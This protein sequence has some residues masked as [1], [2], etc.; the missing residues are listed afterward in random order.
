MKN[1]RIGIAIPEVAGVFAHYVPFNEPKKT[2]K[3]IEEALK[4]KNGKQF[5]EHILN[6]FALSK[7]DDQLKK[8]I[9]DIE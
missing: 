8:I 6:N 4:M 1:I 7:R 2:A 5:R 3:T 9:G